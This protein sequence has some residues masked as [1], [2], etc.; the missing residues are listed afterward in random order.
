MKYS[1]YNKLDDSGYIIQLKNEYNEIFSIDDFEYY[2]FNLTDEE[3]M[4]LRLNGK[5][6]VRSVNE[7]VDKLKWCD[8]VKIDID[9]E[10][11]TIYVVKLKDVEI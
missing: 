3:K 8:K 9:K 7:L 5:N 2:Q 4:F 6:M 10:N 1:L 11:G